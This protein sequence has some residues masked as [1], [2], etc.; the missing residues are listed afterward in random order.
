MADPRVEQTGA[1]P[2]QKQ[3]QGPHGNTIHPLSYELQDFRLC[4]QLHLRMLLEARHLRTGVA[5]GDY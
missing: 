3:L 5:Q 2:D 4:L 1:L